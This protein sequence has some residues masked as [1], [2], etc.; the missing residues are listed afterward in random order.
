MK[1]DEIYGVCSTNGEVR[2]TNKILVGKT[3]GKKI[4]GRPR[5]RLR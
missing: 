5:S 4:F 1:E 3:E 2:N